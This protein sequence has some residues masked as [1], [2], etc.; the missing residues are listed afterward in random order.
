MKQPNNMKAAIVDE[1]VIM[2][3]NPVIEN[4]LDPEGRFIE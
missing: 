3:E 2:N 4:I 1:I